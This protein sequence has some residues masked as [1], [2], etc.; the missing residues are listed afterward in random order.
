MSIRPRIDVE[1]D[2][3][4]ELP[5]TDLLGPSAH[6]FDSP[7]V[8]AIQFALDA[9]RPLLLRGKPGVGKSQLARAAAAVLGWRFRSHVVDAASEARDFCFQVDMVARL[10]DAQIAGA[11]ATRTSDAFLAD[12][13]VKLGIE[14]YVRPGPIWWAIDH[15]GAGLVESK[16]QDRSSPAGAMVTP[17]VSSPGPV[18][19]VVL[20]IDEIDKADGAVPNGLLSVLADAAFDAPGRSVRQTNRALIVFTTNDERTLPDAFVRRCIVHTL[21]FPTTSDDA[22]NRLLQLQEAHFKDLSKEVAKEAAK[23]LLEARASSSEHAA[24]PGFA[25]YLDL[26]RAV[27]TDSAQDA[28]L[29]LKRIGDYA[30]KKHDEGEE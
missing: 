5:G 1:V 29:R 9:G 23:L 8:D 21:R 13:R 19:G 11:L 10:A 22:L 6:V 16:W 2:K 7:S 30:L 4:I 3:P 24:K 12:V 14:H 20:L 17:A 26:L 25:E 28:L 18:P 15:A 27:R